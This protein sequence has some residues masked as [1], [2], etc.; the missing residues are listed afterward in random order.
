MKLKL[1][2]NL[3]PG[4]YHAVLSKIE[5]TELKYGPTLK[6]IYL[7]NEEREII[8]YVSISYSTV[9]KLGRRVLALLNDLPDELDLSSLI[10]IPV[11]VSLIENAEKPEFTKVESVQRDIK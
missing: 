2:H 10:G 7:T 1:E 5:E 11:I 3:A 4:Q 9:S 6:F 8:E